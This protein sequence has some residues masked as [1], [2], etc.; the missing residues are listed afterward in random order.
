MGRR[1]AE[2]SYPVPALGFPLSGGQGWKAGGE[3]KGQRQRAQGELEGWGVMGSPQQWGSLTFPGLCSVGVQTSPGLRPPPNTQ[4]PTPSANH[5]APGDCGRRLSADVRE[6]LSL[7]DIR[8]VTHCDFKRG[9][10]STT[11]E[12]GALK[13][14]VEGSVGG[15]YSTVGGGSQPQGGGAPGKATRGVASL[16]RAKRSSRYTNGSVVGPEIVGGVCSDGN[17]GAP[18]TPKKDGGSEESHSAGGQKRAAER[19]AEPPPPCRS[20]CAPPPRSCAQCG[21]KQSLPPP[22][23][24]LHCRRR[25]GRMRNGASPMSTTCSTHSAPQD[26][27]PSHPTATP[28]RESAPPRNTHQSKLPSRDLHHPSTAPPH[29]NEH[30][31]PIQV[32][33]PKMDHA[34]PPLPKQNGLTGKRVRGGQR[35]QGGL[36]GRLQRVEERL[37]SNQEKIRV[38][39]NVIQDLERNQALNQGRCSYRTGQDLNNCPTCQK[40]ACII[41]SVEHDFRQQEGRFQGVL[42]CLMGEAEGPLKQPPPSP[43]PPT[44]PPPPTAPH[45]VKSK[46]KKLR[47]KCFWWL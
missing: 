28:P 10:A 26:Q 44:P 32:V 13:D 47:R 20:P 15:V 12:G 39:L 18:G 1:A 43:S 41:Y 3:V 36:H 17:G 24:V 35:G 46:A 19:A 11:K 7:V 38:L 8:D 30:T 14:I 5:I 27:S 33:P 40:T 2:P 37:L 31:H 25:G 23:L 45:G 21:R 42:Q 6:G 34:P 29:T 9:G 16:D 4:H 22:C